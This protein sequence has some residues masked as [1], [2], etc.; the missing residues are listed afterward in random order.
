MIRAQI[1]KEDFV[2]KRLQLKNLDLLVTPKGSSWKKVNYSAFSISK[3]RD[4]KSK[5]FLNKNILK[6]FL[7]D[8]YHKYSV[9]VALLNGP[10]LL[11]FIAFSLSLSHFIH[12]HLLKCSRD[13][14]N[15]AY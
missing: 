1:N 2:R 9:Y 11:I 15:G 10:Q 14:H 6:W 12:V 7:F 8:F 3:P 5:W 13:S 4:P